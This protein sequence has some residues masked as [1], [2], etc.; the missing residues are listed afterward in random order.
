MARKASKVLRVDEDTH[1]KVRIMAAEKDK[2]IAEM[3][4]EIVDQAFRDREQEDDSGR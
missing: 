4:K 3:A 1:R 2:E